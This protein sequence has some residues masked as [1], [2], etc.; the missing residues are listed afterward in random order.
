MQGYI[1][2]KKDYA[3]DY[4]DEA[5]RLLD[6]DANESLIYFYGEYSKLMDYITG[7]GVTIAYDPDCNCDSLVDV[8]SVALPPAD[9]D[10]APGAPA[11]APSSSLFSSERGMH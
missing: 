3:E 9:A 2:A 10:H 11:P 1:Y 8:K 4:T 5:V 6:C 7:D